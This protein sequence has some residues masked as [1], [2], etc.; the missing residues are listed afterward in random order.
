[1]AVAKLV[2]P[3]S[4]RNGIGTVLSAVSIELITL[5]T[6][7]TVLSAIRKDRPYPPVPGSEPGTTHYPGDL[8]WVQPA[9]EQTNY[10]YGRLDF[11]N[12]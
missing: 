1:M 11:P 12:G 9:V 2:R 3:K 7:L 5:I 6:F 8:Q 4:S 10:F